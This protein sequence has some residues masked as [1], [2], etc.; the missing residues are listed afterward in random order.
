MSPTLHQPWWTHST[1]VPTFPQL[2]AISHN[3]MMAVLRLAVGGG[4]GENSVQ[5]K[6]RNTVVSKSESRTGLACCPSKHENYHL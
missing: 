2:V 1:L 4:T 3:P 6:I 5:A